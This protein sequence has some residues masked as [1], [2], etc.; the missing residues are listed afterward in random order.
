MTMASNA[1]NDFE[2]IGLMRT[3]TQDDD[4]APRS[5]QKKP[6]LERHISKIP[7]QDDEGVNSEPEVGTLTSPTKLKR[8]IS[9]IPQDDLDSEDER[10]SLQPQQTAK[11]HKHD[12]GTTGS[13]FEVS[14][15]IQVADQEEGHILD[16]APGLERQISNIPQDDRQ[17]DAG[18]GRPRS[19]TNR[20]QRTISSIPNDD[21]DSD[22]ENPVLS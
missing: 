3:R 5:P 6:N 4:N 1:D 18:A 11:L 10:P 22:V 7:Q 13:D 20:L 14:G 2:V 16:K 17:G 9:S 15:S 12:S 21:Y 19:M 8:V